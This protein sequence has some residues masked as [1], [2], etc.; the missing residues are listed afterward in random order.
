MHEP[1][2]KPF[3]GMLFN[4]EKI[5]D[6]ASCVCPPYDVI[7]DART[8]SER[9]RFNIIRLE[10]PEQNPPLDQY[11]NARETLE[12]WLQQGVITFDE[13]DAVY[14]YEQEFEVEHKSFLRRGFIALNKIEKNRMLTH[15]ET[16]KK[17]KEDRER[18][19]SSLKTYTSFVFG[20]YED[21]MQ[22]IENILT[23]APKEII[24]DFIDE[25]FVTN[26]FYKM[27]DRDAINA[28]SKEIDK[29]NIYIADGH[30]RLDVSYR[31]GLSYIPIY[32][33]NMYS[34]G[35]VILPYH[36]MIKFKQ[37]K[38]INEIL[39]SV[40]QYADIDKIL[41]DNDNSLSTAI[42]LISQ[43]DM[44][45]Y[46]L[47]SK[48]APD[49]L[50]MLKV[51]KPIPMDNNMHESLKKLK[52]NIAHNGILK[53]LLYISDDEIEFTQDSHELI[54]DVKKGK[55]DLA[56]LLPPTTVEEVKDI[57]DHSLYMPP[58]STYFYPK[59]L[60]GLVLYRYE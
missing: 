56:L 4:K 2:I 27:T 38:N 48:D 28:L 30:H 29:K 57:A 18:L 8:Y 37:F 10:L 50:Y 15:E 7:S 52:V 25:Q 42:E 22:D 16:R 54:S 5:G 6:V 19:I 26:R 43:S 1:N 24:Y 14:I 20:L 3:R 34:N 59:I 32:L 45:A 51:N 33:T 55:F 39:N 49:V 13:K 9:N 36:R 11:N 46:L 12:H 41:L 47:Y 31:L 44:P 58:K 40:K 23:T 60:T 17:A 21:K 53:G 35:I